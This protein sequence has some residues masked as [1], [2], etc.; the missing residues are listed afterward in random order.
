MTVHVSNVKQNLNKYLDVNDRIFALIHGFFNALKYT[1]RTFRN[2]NLSSSSFGLK[3]NSFRVNVN[4][5]LQ[6]KI[7]QLKI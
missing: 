2:C 5:T 3:I 7:F 6:D 1:S 4:R